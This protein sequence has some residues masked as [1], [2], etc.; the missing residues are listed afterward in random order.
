MKKREERTAPA[1]TKEESIP[2]KHTV[3]RKYFII[4]ITCLLLAEAITEVGTNI[5]LTHVTAPVIFLQKCLIH[6]VKD[7]CQLGLVNEFW[8]EGCSASLSPEMRI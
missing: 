7:S 5:H 8:L 1:G 3:S 2:L 4:I 6:E